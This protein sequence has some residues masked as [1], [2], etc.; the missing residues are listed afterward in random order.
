MCAAFFFGAK[1][2]AE[3]HPV[4]HQGVEVV[5]EIQAVPSP[6]EGRTLLVP[7]TAEIAF[8]DREKRLPI[9]RS[10]WE[11][12]KRHLRHVGD[13]PLNLPVGYSLCFGVGATLGGSIIMVSPGL[14]QVTYTVATVL[15][16]VLGLFLVWLAQHFKNTRRS[17][18]EEIQAD[19]AEI[20]EVFATPSQ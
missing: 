11:R 18:L 19:M 4:E 6:W 1:N 16:F 9:R 20:E 7:V 10:D 2:M 5:R 12:L 3:Q 15:L 13:S 17:M 8:P 14:P